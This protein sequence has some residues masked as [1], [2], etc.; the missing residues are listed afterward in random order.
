MNAREARMR[1]TV[2]TVATVVFCVVI[3]ASNA[4]CRTGRESNAAVVS[5]TPAGETAPPVW[6]SLD[7]GTT[8]AEGFD[9]TRPVREPNEFGS[10]SRPPII[11]RPRANILPLSGA[12]VEDIKS[13]VRKETQR[14]IWFVLVLNHGK[15][16]H[17]RFYPY[18]VEV[19][20]MPERQST[21]I[22]RGSAVYLSEELRGPR[23]RPFSYG[24]VCENGGAFHPDLAPPDNLTR[25]PFKVRGDISDEEII[26]V[27]QFIRS[28]PSVPKRLTY[29][30][31]G[32]TR[33]FFNPDRV[34]NP[35]APIQ[36]ISGRGGVIDVSMVGA[37]PDIVM[38]YRC[39]KID[40][41]WTLVHTSVTLVEILK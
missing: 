33:R 6:Q 16:S 1:K 22:R 8:L 34:E 32:R 12:Q 31:D 19:Y 15:D 25:L 40:G 24:H 5:Q 27:V 4:G 41:A 17:L 38:T 28:G 21:R 13:I 39:Q 10:P 3:I 18:R 26:E 37:R 36:A 7:E 30:P 35:P 14:E 20:T 23:I 9:P 2:R 11:Y 29:G